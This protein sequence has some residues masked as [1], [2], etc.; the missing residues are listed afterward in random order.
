MHENN[1]CTHEYIT[2]ISTTS[3]GSEAQNTIRLRG[4]SIRVSNV[5]NVSPGSADE[6]FTDD[7]SQTIPSVVQEECKKATRY[8]WFYQTHIIDSY[9]P[10]SEICEVQ[11]FGK[12]AELELLYLFIALLLNCL[13]FV[14][15]FNNILGYF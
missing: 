2:C 6:C 8:I 15:S 12:F 13:V 10:I 1:L 3:G 9:S 7:M 11:I 5:S 4:Y 14:F